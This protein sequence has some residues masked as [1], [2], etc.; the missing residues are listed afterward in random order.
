M[1][2]RVVAQRNVIDAR[3]Y[4]DD[5]LAIGWLV[6]SHARN[7]YHVGLTQ[8][9]MNNWQGTFR[10]LP[11]HYDASP[12]G[13]GTFVP[14]GVARLVRQWGGRSISVAPNSSHRPVA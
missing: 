14:S 9:G 6:I 8:S 11:V 5:G 3:C 4:L 1:L 10:R 7:A 13:E 12:T 2:A